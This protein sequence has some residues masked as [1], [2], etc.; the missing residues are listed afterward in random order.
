MRPIILPLL[1]LA[2]CSS[3]STSDEPKPDRAAVGIVDLASREPGPEPNYVTV[4]HILVAVKGPEMPDGLSPEDAAA[5]VETI[6]DDLARGAKWFDLKQE[7]SKDPGSGGVRGGPYAMSNT[8]ALRQRDVT[9]RGKMVNAFGDI[10]FRLEIDEIA[11]APYKVAK[12]PGWSPFGFHII[13][14]VK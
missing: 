14:R 4:D 2:A 12:G 7:F 8:G 13:K 6:L 1:L 3:N 9:P 10:G 5:L 11:V